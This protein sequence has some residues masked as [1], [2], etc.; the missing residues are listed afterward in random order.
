M[1]KQGKLRDLLNNVATESPVAMN[2]LDLPLGR[3]T[4]PIPPLYTD[5][6]TDKH[7]ANL[8]AHLVHLR[9]MGDATSWGTAAT[10]NAVSWMHCD[11]D[12]FSTAVWVQT[13][14]KWWVLAR[15]KNK[16]DPRW[17][18]MSATDTFLKWEVDN[19]DGTRWELEA[20][21]LTPDTV[22]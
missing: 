9:D 21:H 8:V 15:L 14:S 16:E 6:S 22:L 20:V 10:Q 2:V 1:L 11:D 19:I 12:G 5:I 13:G 4:V 17:D 3:T 7:S 18:E